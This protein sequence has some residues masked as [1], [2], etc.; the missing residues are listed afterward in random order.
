MAINANN[1]FNLEEEARTQGTLGGVKLTPEQRKEAFRKQGKIEFK[2][3]V[4]KVLNKKDINQHAHE[5]IS[6]VL[7]KCG[8]EKNDYTVKIS[9]RN[10]T[11][12]LF[13][14]LK[15]TSKSQISTTYQDSTGEIQRNYNYR[16]S[17]TTHLN[18]EIDIWGRLS[19]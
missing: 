2:T 10:I 5:V 16:D 3:F 7:E 14:K 11:D 17:L 4:Q 1:F 6:E 8:L 18:G 15:I 9:S 19:T 13:E 12:R